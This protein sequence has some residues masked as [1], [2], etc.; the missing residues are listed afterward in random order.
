MH[1][2]PLTFISE[3]VKRYSTSY[4]RFVRL[5]EIIIIETE[6]IILDHKC[7]FRHT[8]AYLADKGF[9]KKSRKP[10]LNLRVKFATLLINLA[11]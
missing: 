9:L 3:S 4:R 6:I 2:I 5:Q 11:I 1:Q 10:K 8:Q 7:L